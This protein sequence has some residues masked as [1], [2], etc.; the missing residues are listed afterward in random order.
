M[1]RRNKHLAPSHKT[2]GGRGASFRLC[3][4]TSQIT[5]WQAHCVCAWTHRAGTHPLNFICLTR[6]TLTSAVSP[7]S[8]KQTPTTALRA[9]LADGEITSVYVFVNGVTS[10]CMTI[11]DGRIVGAP[12]DHGASG[13]C[14]VVVATDNKI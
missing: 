11:I 2:S 3:R 1:A 6:A 13:N 4:Q 7:P 14:A 5:H 10:F 12:S 9:G 8:R